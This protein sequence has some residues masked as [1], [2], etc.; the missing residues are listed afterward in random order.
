MT[1]RT[2]QFRPGEKGFHGSSMA[3]LAKRP[4]VNVGHIHHYFESKETKNDRAN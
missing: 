1:W 3:E 2:R 4:G